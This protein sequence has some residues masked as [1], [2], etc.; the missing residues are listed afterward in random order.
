M[1]GEGSKWDTRSRAS[2]TQALPD[3]HDKT[4][5]ALGQERL[6]TPLPQSILEQ[7]FAGQQRKKEM[8]VQQEDVRA[9]GDSCG[10]LAAPQRLQNLST[11]Y[12]DHRMC[13]ITLKSVLLEQNKGKVVW[14]VF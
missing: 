3:H 10:T 1:D 7:L 14:G 6:H 12:C 4:D 2:A 8:Q 13:S 5:M 9:Q 11:T